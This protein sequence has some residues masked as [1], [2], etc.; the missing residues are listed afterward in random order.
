MNDKPALQVMHEAIES[1][2]KLPDAAFV[3]AVRQAEADCSRIKDIAAWR[4]A[5]R[6][7]LDF[8]LLLKR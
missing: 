2:D 4:E 1:F 3:N 7:E 6:R 5:V 8:R